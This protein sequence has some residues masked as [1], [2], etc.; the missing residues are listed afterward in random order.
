[1]GWPLGERMLCI[2]MVLKLNL[3]SWG[4]LLESR[5][6]AYLRCLS[7]LCLCRFTSWRAAFMNIYVTIA[8]L[9][10]PLEA[11][12]EL[13]WASL[14][15]LLSDGLWRLI[16]SNSGF[17]CQNGSQMASGRSFWGVL[18]SG[19]RMALRWPL[20]A[21]FELFWALVPE[22]LSVGSKTR[23]FWPFDLS[24]RSSGRADSMHNYGA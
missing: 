3:P 23:G 2:F 7:S 19:A 12:F 16:L 13:L 21:V 22:W 9:R 20:D 10:W 1:M 24:W 8:P 15:E 5:C 4:D 11:H 17:N 18:G 14:P 6:Y